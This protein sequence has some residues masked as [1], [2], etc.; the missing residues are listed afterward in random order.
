MDQ[1]AAA[2]NLSA[3]KMTVLSREVTALIG[4]AIKEGEHVGPKDLSLMPVPPGATAHE[5]NG[6]V[7]LKELKTVIEPPQPV[8]QTTVTLPIASLLQRYIPGA[9]SRKLMT[10]HTGLIAELREVSV[11]FIKTTGVAL[12]AEA[13]GSVEQVSS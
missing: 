6:F 1:I 2:E 4:S 10:G 8:P 12:S 3:S 5:W 7:S 13:N 9:V 11:L